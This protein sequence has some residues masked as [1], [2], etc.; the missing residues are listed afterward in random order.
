MAKKSD[1]HFLIYHHN[2]FLMN[3]K[4]SLLLISFCFVITSAFSQKKTGSIFNPREL[5]AQNFF[6]NNGNEFRS[7]NGAPGPKYWQNRADYILHATIDTVK[8]TLTCTETISY[9]NN[10]PDALPSLWLQLD[11]NTYRKEARSNFYSNRGGE[12]HTDGYQ[13][14]T[15][16]IEYKGKTIKANYIINDTRMQIRLPN[17]LSSKEKINIHDK[18]SLFYPG[19]VWRKK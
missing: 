17:A 5:F 3:F 9:S 12:G 6:T 15:V 16:T 14:E 19:K 4:S 18:L 7:A 10:S 2:F 8:N 11:Q 13:F 1:L